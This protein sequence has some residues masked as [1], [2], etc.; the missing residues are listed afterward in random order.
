MAPGTTEPVN[1]G[2]GERE[3]GLLQSV[4]ERHPEIERVVLFGS[5]AKGTHRSNSDID[6]ALW[7]AVDALAAAEVAGELDEL[8]LPY[9]FDVQPYAQIKVKS[10][11]EHIDRVGLN[12]YQRGEAAP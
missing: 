2:L 4:F 8:P 10:L 11:Q 9:L 5:R 6:L 7:G 3:L 1:T 12:L